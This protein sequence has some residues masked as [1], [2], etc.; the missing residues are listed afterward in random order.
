M[1]WEDLPGALAVWEY[2]RNRPPGKMTNAEK[3]ANFEAWQIICAQA[4]KRIKLYEGRRSDEQSLPPKV[5]SS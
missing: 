4:E 3:E 2:L 1:D 5:S